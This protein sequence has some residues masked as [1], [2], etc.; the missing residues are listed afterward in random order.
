VNPNPPPRHRRNAFTLVELLVVIGIIAL[1]ISILLPSLNQARENAKATQCLSNIRQVGIAFMMYANEN[2]GYIPSLT[3]SRSARRPTDWL[4]WQRGRDMKESNVA[5]FLNAGGAGVSTDALRCP[6]D[7]WESHLS[8]GNAAADGPYFYSYSVS[9]WL[10]NNGDPKRNVNIGRVKNAT[11]K[12]FIV[13]EDERT[14]DDGHWVGDAGVGATN[15]GVSNYLAIR[16]DRK[17]IRPDE[18]A[19]WSR[20][21]DRRGNVVYLDFHAEYAPRREAHDR[22]NQDPDSR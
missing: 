16:H 21:L 14:I 19:N 9:T 22:R 13:E 1:L 20:N 6:S 10:M 18:S 7:N 5:R 12:V 15:G 11:R 3:A 4:Y 2:K 17:R 8:P